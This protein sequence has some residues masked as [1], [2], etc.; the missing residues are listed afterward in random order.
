I[1]TRKR[2]ASTALAWLAVVAFLPFLGAVAY[3]MF[4]EI[5]LGRRR[6]RQYQHL[7][8]AV[9]QSAALRRQFAL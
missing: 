2:S 5:R 7:R 9:S 4:G 8:D 6:S 1:V 3:L